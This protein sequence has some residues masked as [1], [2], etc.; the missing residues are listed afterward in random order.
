MR[1]AVHCARDEH[2]DAR[3]KLLGIVCRAI[4][5]VGQ[6]DIRDLLLTF[7]DLFVEERQAHGVAAVRSATKE[8]PKRRSARYRGQ[9]KQRGTDRWLL[10][11]YIGSYMVRGKRHKRYQ[12]KTVY[13]TRQDAE[14]ALMVMLAV[15]HSTK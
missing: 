7:V 10:E 14:A 12:A 9:I 4:R 3:P 8:S 6:D 11:I 1:D 2:R 13:G 5:V 15:A